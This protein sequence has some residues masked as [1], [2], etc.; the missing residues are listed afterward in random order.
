[1]EDILKSHTK[2]TLPVICSG[3]A[4]NR[5]AHKRTSHKRTCVVVICHGQ[6]LSIPTPL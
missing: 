6:G 1:M 2:L 3:C 4:G 5:E